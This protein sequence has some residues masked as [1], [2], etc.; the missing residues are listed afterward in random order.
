MT[1]QIGAHGGPAEERRVK[2]S[3]GEYDGDSGRSSR[4]G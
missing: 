4:V 3:P 1:E 2:G